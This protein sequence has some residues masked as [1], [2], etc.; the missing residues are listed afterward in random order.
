MAWGRFPQTNDIT[1]S[2]TIRGN[3]KE[4]LHIAFSDSL[5]RSVTT[6]NDEEKRYAG[7][8]TVENLGSGNS[9]LI[10]E[11]GSYLKFEDGFAKGEFDVEVF[12][13]SDEGPYTQGKFTIHVEPD[14]QK[15]RMKLRSRRFKI[16]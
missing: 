11:G 8:S 10:P 1:D 15:L 13:T 9:N 14:F 7:I 3:G 12:I 6:A 16:F 5:F 2:R 4:L